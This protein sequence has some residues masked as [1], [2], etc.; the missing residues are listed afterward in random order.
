MHFFF[1]TLLDPFRVEFRDLE[2]PL[3]TPLSLRYQFCSTR[4]ST[5]SNFCLRFN[6]R[7]SLPIRCLTSGSIVFFQSMCSMHLSSRCRTFRLPLGRRSFFSL[8]SV[9]SLSVGC[10]ARYWAQSWLSLD[11]VRSLVVG[12]LWSS[13]G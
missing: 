10:R 12:G 13:A 8:T 6:S 1:F 3:T 4:R 7:R 9:F 2:A 5:F 11:A